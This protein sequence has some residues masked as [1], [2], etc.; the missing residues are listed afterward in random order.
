MR[1][2]LGRFGLLKTFVLVAI[3]M[4]A[5]AAN[6][7]L[8]R[9]ALANTD[10][11]PASFTILR[12]ASGA[13]ALFLL[14]SYFQHRKS[15]SVPSQGLFHGLKTNASVLGGISLFVYAICFSYAYISMSTGTG[16]LLLFGAVQ[17]TMISVG[18]FNGERFK[19]WQWLGFVLAFLGL[20]ILLLPSAAA[21]PL[22][23]GAV[24]VLAG[25]AWG[26]YS[27]LGK[28]SSSALLST[29]GNFVYAAFF[30]VPLVGVVC[31][32]GADNFVLDSEG[33]YYALASG[34]FA[35]GCGYAIWY[36]ALPLIKST[37]AATVQLSVPV[38]ASLM[39]WIA[40]GEP[41]TMQILVASI[42]TLGGIYL[43]IKK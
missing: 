7:L 21:P 15:E 8:C 29:S 5:F 11:D 32:V 12:L 24:M 35:S 3:A 10:I 13:I 4:I 14:S 37:T 20:V 36:S 33:V 40:L 17:L 23:A 25:M 19:K 31:F 1:L 28:K 39:G 9:M 22:L 34:V 41:L 42:A 6:S 30:C 18:L 43:V 2:E 38:I 26:V 27:L 16:A